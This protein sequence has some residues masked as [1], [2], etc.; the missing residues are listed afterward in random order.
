MSRA[1]D[2]I[3]ESRNY[4]LRF[5]VLSAMLVVA[6]GWVVYDEPQ[7]ALCIEPMTGPPDALNLAQVVVSPEHPLVA[8]AHLEWLRL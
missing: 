1:P 6:T 4:S 8:E 7:H 5:F 2:P 3:L